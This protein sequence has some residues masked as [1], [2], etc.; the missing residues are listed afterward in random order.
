MPIAVAR[1]LPAG[2][3]W[4]TSASETANIA[5]APIPCT[6]REMFKN[7]ASGDSPAASDAIANRPSP[8]A[9]T[10]RRPMRSAIEPAVRTTAASASVY[11]SITH[12]RSVK[13]APRSFW[14]EGSAVLTTVMSSSSMNVPMH[15]TISVHHLRSISALD[16]TRRLDP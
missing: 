15:T 8:A 9:N 6:A 10:A 13:L 3:S 1:S 12:C 7:V 4:A 16:V 11:A 14:T 5:A 2:N